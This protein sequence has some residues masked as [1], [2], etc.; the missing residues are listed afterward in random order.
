MADR[1]ELTDDGTLDTV[2]RCSDC[3]EEI[4]CSYDGGFAD[5]ADSDD[6]R[7]DVEL[8]ELWRDDQQSDIEDEHECQAENRMQ[9]DDWVTEDYR[10]FVTH[11]PGRESVVVYEGEDWRVVLLTRMEADQFWPNVWFISDHGN[12]SALSM[13]TED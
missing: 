6:T 13:Q 11:S 9:D 1:I 12:V 7:S 8:Y 4:R 5:D 10:T 2:F 3:G